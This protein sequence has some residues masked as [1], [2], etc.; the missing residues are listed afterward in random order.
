[1]VPTTTIDAAAV[2]DPSR[3]PGPVPW[4]GWRPRALARFVLAFYRTRLARRALAVTVF[5]HVYLGGAAMFWYHSVLLGEGGPAISPVLHWFVD[6]TA[7]LVA[8][9][10]VLVVILPFAGRHAITRPGVFSRA[11]F[12]V[13]GGVAFALATGPGPVLHDNLVG[14]GTWLADQ[15]TRAWGDGRP[16]GPA[17][18]IAPALDMLLQVAWGLPVYTAL[19]WL[20]VTG[21]RAAGDRAR[22]PDRGGG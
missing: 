10:P 2:Y 12:A 3:A 15:V 1:M 8:L 11:R 13:F 16:L 18:H 4:P 14:R 17:E 9:T 20:T 6:S 21:I 22:D 5:A 7:G 19:M